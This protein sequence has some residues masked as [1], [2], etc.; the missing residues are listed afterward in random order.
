MVEYYLKVN[1]DKGFPGGSAS[2]ESTCNAGD[3][4]SI[5][6]WGRSP[7]KGNGYP[8][9]YSY[10]GNPVKEEPEWPNHQE[11]S[12]T[13]YLS[14]PG[15]SDGKRICL[16]CRKP[17]FNPWVQKITWRR[18]WQPIP[19]FLPGE[20][21]GQRILAGYRQSMGSLRIGHDWIDWA[22]TKLLFF[23]LH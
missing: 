2:K 4:G 22:C 8:L 17:G 13:L 5:P 12:S 15:G 14:F 16:Q 1:C 9:Q 7:E 3:A 21:P 23:L 18:E 19:V 11:R 10:L 6:G 20:F